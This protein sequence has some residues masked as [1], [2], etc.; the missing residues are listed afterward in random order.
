MYKIVNIPLSANFQDTIVIRTL[1]TSIQDVINF[2]VSIGLV[3]RSS[4]QS[5]AIKYTGNMSDLDL[6]GWLDDINPAVTIILDIAKT[7]IS[8]GATVF[9]LYEKFGTEDLPELSI[10]GATS[11]M[12]I[13]LPL[14]LA[15]IQQKLNSTEDLLLLELEKLL[16]ADNAIRILRDKIRNGEI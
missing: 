2:G 13:K 9:V 4:G 12:G 5:A 6:T 14:E 1:S 16:P 3:A 11:V 10:D 7:Y 8:T 15:S